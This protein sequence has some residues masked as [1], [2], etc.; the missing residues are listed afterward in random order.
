MGITWADPAALA[1]L[2]DALL[3]RTCHVEKLN[4]VQGS[5]MSPAYLPA[6]ARLLAGRDGAALNLVRVID[7]DSLF[8]DSSAADLEPLCAALRR[9]TLTHFVLQR[10][11]LTERSSAAL[12]QAAE[13]TPRLSVIVD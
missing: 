8:A 10:V 4:L 12:R 1:A 3:A 6:L 11:G 13:A 7:C 2:A 5:G 9:T